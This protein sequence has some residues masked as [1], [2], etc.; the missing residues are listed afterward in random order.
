MGEALG[1]GCAGLKSAELEHA[2]GNLNSDDYTALKEQYMIEA[3]VVMKEMELGE[4][5]EEDLLDSI[6]LEMVSIRETVTGE[7]VDN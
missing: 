4:K 3:S 2:I 7:S 1:N 6:R 5:Q